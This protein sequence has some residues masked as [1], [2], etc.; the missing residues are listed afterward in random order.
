VCHV[1]QRCNSANRIAAGEALRR[2]RAPACTVARAGLT[3][4][5][6]P[7]LRS[8]GEI[9]RRLQALLIGAGLAVAPAAF[10][11]PNPDK[12]KPDTDSTFESFTF[13]S[14][15]RLGVMVIQLTPE[16][17]T[18]FG[19]ANDRGVLVGRVEPKSAAEAAGLHV[20][21]VLTEVKGTAIDDAMDVISTLAPLKANENVSLQVVRDGKTLTLTATM[22]D[23]PTPSTMRF[24]RRMPKW[25]REFMTPFDD[26]DSPSPP[27]KS[28]ST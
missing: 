5:R 8:K 6:S 16:L 9:M 22:R 15:A 1:A 11:H 23:N 18:H 17:R 24:D 4:D 14:R 7:V 21:D 2:M 10:A 12:A 3:R 25:F 13:S 20:G 19:A 27:D 26:D 28:K